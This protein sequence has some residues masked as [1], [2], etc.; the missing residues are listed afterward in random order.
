MQK[1][2]KADDG[3]ASDKRK[4]QES[5]LAVQL[6]NLVPDKGMVLRVSDILFSL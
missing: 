4:R 1:V 6:P 3:A 5:E 2:Q